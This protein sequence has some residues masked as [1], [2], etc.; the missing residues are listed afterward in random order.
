MNA[1]TA[2]EILKPLNL[3]GKDKK[4]LI[5][6]LSGEKM[7]LKKNKVLTVASAKADF[8]NRLQNMVGW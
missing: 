3:S 2:F 7:G 8:K 1:K 4:D 5:K 6:L